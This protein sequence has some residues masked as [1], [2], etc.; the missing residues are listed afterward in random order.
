MY[1]VE[2]TLSCPKCGDPLDGAVNRKLPID[3]DITGKPF[4]IVPMDGVRP[5]QVCDKDG[6]I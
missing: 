1:E 3:R 5:C 4:V 6:E 2:T